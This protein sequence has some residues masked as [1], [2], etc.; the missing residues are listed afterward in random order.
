MIPDQISKS[1]YTKEIAQKFE[2][3]ETIIQQELTRQIRNTLGKNQ[4][5][6]IPVDFTLK[7]KTQQKQQLDSKPEIKEK[8]HCEYDL[9]RILLKYGVYAIE[10][11]HRNSYNQIESIEISV[12][13]LICN[14]LHRDELYFF[15]PTYNKIFSQISE[16]ISNKQFYRISHFLKSADI[17]ITKLVSEIETDTYEL[18]HNWILQKNIYTNLEIDK[19]KDAVYSSLY[20]FKNNKIQHRIDEIRVKIATLQSEEESILEDLLIEQMN[21][22]KLK[23]AFSHALGRIIIR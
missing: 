1:I 23:I 6:A 8:N 20:S 15:D 3:D 2:I 12:S 22:E 4:E 9:I 13:E 11:E 14:E 7:F 10:T 16:G 18:S 19:L 17:E 5:Q 21:L